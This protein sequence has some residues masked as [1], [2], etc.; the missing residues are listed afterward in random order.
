MSEAL[1][2]A[3][4]ARQTEGQFPEELRSALRARGRTIFV[5]RDQ[6]IVAE[7][8][9]S[10]DVFLIISGSVKIS[11]FSRGG[12]E[13]IL[14]EMGP[15]QL[16]G[17]LAAIDRQPRSA[18]VVAL[19]DTSLI[20]LTGDEF[21]AFLETAPTGALWMARQLSMRVRDLTQKIFELTTMPVNTRLH[22]ELVRL[23][24]RSGVRDDK[25]VIDRFPTHS[26]L[27]SNIGSHREAISRELAY[28]TKQAI[29]KQTGR[30]MLILSVSRLKAMALQ[31]VH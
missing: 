24:M 30:K 6:I 28:L 23:G 20:H 17:E 15:G 27:A 5:R 31:F 13:T 19:E 12:R 2:G 9:D 22:C 25:A 4:V 14:R 16:F 7:G 26:Y 8:L 21:L 10:T 11:L 29:L 3:E 18:S 1:T